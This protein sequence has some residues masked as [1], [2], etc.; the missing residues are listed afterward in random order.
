MAMPCRVC[1]RMKPMSEFTG[2]M[3][4]NECKITPK[5][6][7][8]IDKTCRVCKKV[9]EMIA[10]TIGKGTCKECRNKAKRKNQL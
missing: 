5:R 9:K 6:P 8:K 10:F 2:M 4:C 7:V 1:E 3:T